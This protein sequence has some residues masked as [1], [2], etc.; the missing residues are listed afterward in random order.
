MEKLKKNIIKNKKLNLNLKEDLEE[1]IDI[2]PEGCAEDLFF[3]KFLNDDK[4][5]TKLKVDGS[6]MKLFLNSLI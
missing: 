4:V 6:I 1:E 3:D 2:W 5:K